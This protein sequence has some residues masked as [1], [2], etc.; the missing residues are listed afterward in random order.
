MYHVQG[1]NSQTAPTESSTRNGEPFDGGR[2]RLK[3]ALEMLQ[4]SL[5]LCAV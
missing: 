2:Q 3:E 5:L 4:A 1:F